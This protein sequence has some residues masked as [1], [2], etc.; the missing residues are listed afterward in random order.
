MVHFII[1]M[2]LLHLWFVILA[3]TYNLHPCKKAKEIFNNNDITIAWWGQ[4]ENACW[5][6]KWD[7]FLLF[8]I[9]FFIFFNADLKFTNKTSQQKFPR[10]LLYSNK[11]NTFTTL[12]PFKLIY[13]CHVS[14]SHQHAIRFSSSLCRR[15][16]RF[17]MPVE[18]RGN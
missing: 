7:N 9:Y 8:I 11:L 17:T 14:F 18:L 4:R 13:N 5:V 12:N 16:T 3:N 15:N 6:Y 2:W 10:F 1:W